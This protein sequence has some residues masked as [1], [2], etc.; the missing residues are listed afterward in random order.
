MFSHVRKFRNFRVL[1]IDYLYQIDVFMK[2]HENI[3]RRNVNSIGKEGV[4]KMGV[5]KVG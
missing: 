2:I 1:T 3:G 5:H 4:D